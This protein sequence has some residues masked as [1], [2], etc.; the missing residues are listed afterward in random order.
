M[1]CVQV[2]VKDY[3]I[4]I[5]SMQF[6]VSIVQNDC[7]L[8]DLKPELGKYIFLDYDHHPSDKFLDIMLR[9]KVCYM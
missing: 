2:D 6:K 8:D 9:K 4:E 1:M 7:K 3:P 5:R